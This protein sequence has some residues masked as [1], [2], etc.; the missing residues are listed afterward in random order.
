MPETHSHLSPKSLCVYCSSSNVIGRHYFDAAE[1][2]GAL[3]GQRGM[4]LVYGGGN[5]GLMGALA[6][7]VHRHH[8][9]GIGV[10]PGFMKDKEIGYHLAD[11]LIIT[12]DIG[13]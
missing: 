7:A 3:I 13:E 6:L 8:G 5:V 9:K 4:T 11:G 10:I 2:V 12:G 1:E